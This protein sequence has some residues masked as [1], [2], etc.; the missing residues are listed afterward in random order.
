MAEPQTWRVV[1]AT[2][3]VREVRVEISPDGRVWAESAD[4]AAEG[5]GADAWLA[6]M[7]VARFLGVSV[8]E[9]LAPGEPTRAE[10]VAQL[11]AVTAER[12]QWA[13][14]ARAFQVE[15]DVALRHAEPLTRDVPALV[16]E[17]RRLTA[18]LDA[19]RREG[20]EAMRAACAAL[21]D[22]RARELDEDADMEDDE[23][24]EQR[25]YEA[26][27]VADAIRALPLDARRLP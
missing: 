27:A 10:L 12:E 8:R 20:A 17:V 18:A 14:W 4:G 7:R 11:A 2:G 15:R 6:V 24:A 23:D 9:I 3:E 13:Q 26:L 19:A 22:R 1:L 25:R 16:A 5:A 21:C